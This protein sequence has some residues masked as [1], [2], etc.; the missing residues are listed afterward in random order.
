MAT[1]TESHRRAELR[2]ARKLAGGSA[3][4]D[5][6]PGEEFRVK[7]TRLTPA[8]VR[9]LSRIDAWLATRALLQTGGLGAACIAVAVRW[10]HPLVVAAAL[11]GIAG[12]QHGLAV[13]TH[14]AAHYRLYETRWLNDLVG[15]LCAIPLGVSMVTYRVIHRIH[16]NHLYEPID[17]DLALMAGYP[18]G[19]LY[20]A[21]KLLKDLLGV[22]TLKN[23]RYFKAQRSDG[24]RLTDDTSPALRSAARRDR[25]LV[26]AA[27]LALLAAAIASG[28]WRWYLLLWLLPL[29]TLLQA[30]L[31]LRAV[32]EHGA[33]TDKTTPLRAARTTRVWLGARWLLFPHH[34]YYHIEHHLY[35]S[36]PHY[37]LAECHARLTALGALDGAEVVPTLRE[38][39]AKIFA[40]PTADRS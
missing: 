30:I 3:D 34:V 23:Y 4:G 10:P 22:T 29:V 35:P 12:A 19:R 31:R 32:C 39:L 14:E 8:E 2:S 28:V 25:Y 16:H 11:V 9:A 37:R 18:R 13:S 26:L 15:K 33:I 27:Q 7:A 1:T 24:T 38:T 17:P 5:A 6:R 20:L 40:E 36:V 21:R